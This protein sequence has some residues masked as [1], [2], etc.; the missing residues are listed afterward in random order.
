MAWEMKTFF[1]TSSPENK[2]AEGIGKNNEHEKD[3]DMSKIV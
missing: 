2:Y 3:H 1:C